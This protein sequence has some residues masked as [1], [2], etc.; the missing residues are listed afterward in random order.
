MNPSFFSDSRAFQD[1]LCNTLQQM[2]EKKLLNKN[3]EFY[4]KLIINLP[5][6]MENHGTAGMFAAWAFWTKYAKSSY[7]SI[8]NQ[9]LSTRFCK[10]GA[11]DDPDLGRSEG[12]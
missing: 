2:Y 3:E 11:G 8:Y 12:T 5:P 6:N 4:D 10:D 7:Y 9:T 1:V